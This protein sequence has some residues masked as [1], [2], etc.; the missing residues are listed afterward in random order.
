[1]P[2]LT[3]PALADAVVRLRPWRPG[4]ADAQLA[5]F[6]DP[7]FLR[8]SDWA[9]TG[10][11]EVLGRIASVER[12]RVEGRGLHLA[13]VAADDPSAVLGEV[14]LSGIDLDQ[15]RASVGYWLAPAARGRGAAARAVR[16]LTRWALTD[17]GLA[18][19]ELTCGP[20]N[21]ASQKVATRCGFQQEG[22]L[23]EHLRFTGGRR[24]SLLFSL[25]PSDLPAA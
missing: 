4:D 13:V 12:A 21:L 10:R 14:S 11:E 5:A 3:V 19:L 6:C 1:M 24:D 20:D 2:T 9:P 23:R 22:L 25:L 7:V 17:L 15:G 8:F 18:R 16:L